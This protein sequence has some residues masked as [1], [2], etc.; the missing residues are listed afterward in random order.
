MILSM[1]GFGE[2]QLEHDGHTYHLEIR[3]V[4]NR[5]FKA[6]IRVPDE[7][8]FLEAQIEQRLRERLVRG[9]LTLKLHVR[10]LSAAA[11]QDLN[12]AAIQRYV[13]QLRVSAGDDTRLTIDLAMLATLPGVCQP[14]D[15]T[16][17]ERETDAARVL[18]LLDDAI[19]RL[20]SM[21]STEG[22]ALSDDLRRHAEL[23]RTRVA[24]IRERCPDV[25]EE[26]RA[27]LL[28][29]IEQLLRGSNVQ[30]AQDDVLK[31]VSIYADRSDVS[32]ELARL[33]SHVEQF[34]A[35]MASGEPSGRKLDF[36][37]QEMLRE[38]N[39]IGSKAGDAAVA[40]DV[41][42][43]KSAVDRIKEQVQNVV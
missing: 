32:E 14:H 21:R 28:S 24:A 16:S 22:Q 25:V 40:R 18:A 10:D 20:E 1:T 33:D 26:Y 38:A 36:L 12:A 5:Y 34:L 2:A 29:R 15:L 8:A 27:R 17:A 42:D 43:I 4:N 11:A 41:I 35:F 3:S 31:E 37:A 7:Y 23:V 39:T 30:L 19:V 13:E 9:S 6:S